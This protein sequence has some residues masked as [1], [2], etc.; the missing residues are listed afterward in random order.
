[1]IEKLCSIVILKL[2]LC[3]LSKINLEA[4]FAICNYPTPAFHKMMSKA[5][6]RKIGVLKNFAIFTG[7]HGKQAQLAQKRL[8]NVASTLVFTSCERFW[9]VI[10]GKFI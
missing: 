3:G 10:F 2:N 9:N 4:I 5:A 6:N 8:R 7:K 1:M